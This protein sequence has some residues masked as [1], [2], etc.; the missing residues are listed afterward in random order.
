VTV[1]GSTAV[2][3]GKVPQ[4]WQ[5]ETAE[6]AV[7]RFRVI[8]VQNKIRVTDRLG[9]AWSVRLTNACRPM[10][11]TYLI[12]S[13]L[14]GT[15][16]G[17]EKALRGF[18][19]WADSRRDFVQ[20]AYASGRLFES[21]KESIE[22]K[23]LPVP[24]AII[25]AVG[26]NIYA[27]PSGELFVAWHRQIGNDWNAE[28]VRDILSDFQGLQL[29]PEDCQARYKV[30]Y[31][32]HDADAEDIQRLRRRL[33]EAAIEAEVIYSSKR[34]LD[35]LP[36][37]ADKG[38]AVVFLARTWNLDHKNVIVCGNSG[39]DRSMFEHGFRGI[40]VANAHHELRRLNRPD[41]YHAERPFAAGVVEGLHHWLGD[42]V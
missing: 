1:T 19:E 7:R 20:L 25:G 23:P 5:K 9:K 6:S 10:E 4:L 39:N 28:R 15:L 11:A 22:T 2:L 27:Y 36:A 8:H 34:D 42:R 24:D 38:A 30:S 16:L 12:V 41:V 14:D 3:P 17:D 31:Y 35:V 37:G 26:T 21:V 33:K 32:Y 18:A 13:D 29:Q 40:V